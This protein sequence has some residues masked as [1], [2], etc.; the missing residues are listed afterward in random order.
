MNHETFESLDID[1]NDWNLAEILESSRT[2]IKQKAT[3]ISH[4][5]VEEEDMSYIIQSLK[6]NFQFYQE[7]IF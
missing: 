5:D 2:C 6:M 7:I 4:E 1:E 3:T